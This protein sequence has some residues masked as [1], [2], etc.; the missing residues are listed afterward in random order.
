[1]TPAINNYNFGPTKSGTIMQVSTENTYHCNGSKSDSKTLY[2]QKCSFTMEVSTDNCKSDVD[3]QKNDFTME[4]STENT[5]H[6]NGSKSDLVLF[7]SKV[8]PLPD[9]QST[10][11][12]NYCL[13]TVK[14]FK[15][16]IEATH[17]AELET[18][19]G[20]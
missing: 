1:M 5:Y 11:T 12:D 20:K 2:Q 16:N 3:H 15:A 19:N 6:C 18:Y 14:S 8:A 17:D 7:L 13:H 10:P 9:P 4:V